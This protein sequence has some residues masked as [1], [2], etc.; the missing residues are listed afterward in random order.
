MEEHNCGKRKNDNDDDSVGLHAQKR[1]D[2]LKKARTTEDDVNITSATSKA[3]LDK[4]IHAPIS[5]DKH[6][7]LFKEGFMLPKKWNSCMASP[8]IFRASHHA[9]N[10]TTSTTRANK[11][12]YDGDS[13]KSEDISSSDPLPYPGNTNIVDLTLSDDDDDPGEGATAVVDIPLLTYNIWFGPQQEFLHNESRMIKIASIIAS[14]LDPPPI[15]V[16]LQEVT[17][18]LSTTLFPL[19]Q[20]SG[21]NIYCQDT[22]KQHYATAVAVRTSTFQN[23][24]IEVLSSGVNSYNDTIQ[25]RAFVWVVARVAGVV[26]LFTNTHLESFESG[27]RIPSAFLRSGQANYDGVLERANQISDLKGFCE[28]CMNDYPQIRLAVI[29]GDLNWDDERMSGRSTGLDAALNI[30]TGES[31][32]DMWREIN[33]SNIKGFTYD[34]RENQMLTGNLRRRFDRCL[35]KFQNINSSTTTSTKTIDLKSITTVKLVGTEAIEGLFYGKVMKGYG[36]KPTGEIR[37]L[38]VLPSDHFGLSV[39][40]RL[41]QS[42]ESHYPDGTPKKKSKY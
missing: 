36:F 16:G 1:E 14:D 41:E 23:E 7:C 19:L 3:A 37:N 5:T 20:M 29:S 6:R 17:L 18:E 42:R 9:V 10:T 22:I 4:P 31:W 39:C 30:F 35:V 38:P 26:V 24:P 15:F 25:G 34:S 11:G 21:Y 27:Q 2:T 8:L 12:G 32:K 28:A 40:I 13:R 33:G